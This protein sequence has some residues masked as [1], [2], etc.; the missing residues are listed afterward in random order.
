MKQNKTLEEK[1]EKI[2]VS[3]FGLPLYWRDEIEIWHGMVRD[4][5][6]ADK[7]YN[8]NTAGTNNVQYWEVVVN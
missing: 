2:K 6:N 5:K 1:K 4:V 8:L 7:I 3:K